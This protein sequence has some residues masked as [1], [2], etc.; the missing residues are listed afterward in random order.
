[1][2][3]LLS[4]T[5]AKQ[6]QLVRTPLGKKT[7]VVLI[8]QLKKSSVGFANGCANFS[9]QKIIS[10]ANGRPHNMSALG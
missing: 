4:K 5:G 9:A 2:Y 10:R 3:V 6:P 8:F 1:M 7:T